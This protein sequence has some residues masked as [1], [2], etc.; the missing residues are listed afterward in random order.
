[1]PNNVFTQFTVLYTIVIATS[2]AVTISTNTNYRE[3]AYP[4]TVTFPTSACANNYAQ[5]RIQW[6][7]EFRDVFDSKRVIGPRY[8]SDLSIRSPALPPGPNNC[9][10][11]Q[12]VDFQVVGCNRLQYVC[13]YLITTLSRCRALTIDGEA[14]NKCS[15]AASADR[16]ADIG[17][18]STY[19]AA[20]DTYH[21][22]YTNNYN[23]PIN[24]L[25]DLQCSSINNNQ[26]SHN[27]QPCH[28]VL[29]NNSA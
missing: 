18:N 17:P 27:H 15:Y 7:L 20:L 4:L 10:G 2:G 21:E 24:R 28:R 16:I 13:T 19:S 8:L 14:F 1:M 22:F 23:C 26:V 9:F 29:L 3:L 12:I 11:D 6:Q 25:N 5:M